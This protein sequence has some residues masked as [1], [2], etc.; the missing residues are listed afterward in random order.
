MLPS[1]QLL[2]INETSLIGLSNSDA[3]H[4]LRSS[5]E[6]SLENGSICIIIGRPTRDHHP[7]FSNNSQGMSPIL[8]GGSII[9]TLVT[10]GQDT[11]LSEDIGM[12]KMFISLCLK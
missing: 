3:M 1:D 8:H 9:P 6:S 2:C 11:K 4:V 5:M 12:W 7:S 10:S